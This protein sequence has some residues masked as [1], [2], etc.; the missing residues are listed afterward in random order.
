VIFKEPTSQL[1]L[2]GMR[3]AKDGVFVE[4]PAGPQYMCNPVPPA[5]TCKR[6][7]EQ[8]AFPQPAN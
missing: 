4:V 8:L 3:S 7:W 1:P 5:T 2:T 6:T